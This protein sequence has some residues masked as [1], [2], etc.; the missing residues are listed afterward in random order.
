MAVAMTGHS[1][2]MRVHETVPV[3]LYNHLASTSIDK[4]RKV[5]AVIYPL[6]NQIMGMQAFDSFAMYV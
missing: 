6:P 2:F 5:R 3:R 4:A 1:V